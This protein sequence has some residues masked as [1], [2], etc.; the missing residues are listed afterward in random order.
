[1]QESLHHQS[2]LVTGNE[3]KG[4]RGQLDI[5]TLLVAL[6]AH[7]KQRRIYRNFKSFLLVSELS[8]CIVTFNKNLN[9]KGLYIYLASSSIASAMVNLLPA[10]TFA[11]AYIVG[12]LKKVNIQSFRSIAKIIGTISSVAGA[13]SMPLLKGPRTLSMELQLMHSLFKKGDEIWLLGCF[14]PLAGTICRSTWQLL[15]VPVV[16]ELS[17]SFTCNSMQGCASWL[18]CN[19]QLSRFL[20]RKISQ[21]WKLHS[22]LEIGCPLYT[23]SFSSSILYLAGAPAQSWCISKRGPIFCAMPCL[24]P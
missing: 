1:M 4:F 18:P 19:L 20:L 12:G 10:T 3:S 5:A 14:I 2:F 17:R 13:I 16:Q 21:A 22:H 9:F 8:V 7:F 6:V 15:Q 11:A 23:V 24:I